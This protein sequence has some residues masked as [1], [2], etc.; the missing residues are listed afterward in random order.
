MAKSIISEKKG[1]I[2]MLK[3]YTISKAK[4]VNLDNFDPEDTDRFTDK[5]EVTDEF[6]EM[7]DTLRD[8]QEKLFA[9]KTHSVLILFQGM[10]C[11]GKDGVI[12]KVL[13]IL[14][15]QGFRLRALSGRRRKRERTIFFGE[16]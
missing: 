14:N 8:Y 16:P 3:K 5:S 4:E 2:G 13:S 15:P 9:S 7:E 12:K 6:M 1:K 10:D 11:S